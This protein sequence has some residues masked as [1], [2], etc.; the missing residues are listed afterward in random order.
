[1]ITAELLKRIPLFAG[2]PD[3]ERASLAARAAD[4]R[5]NA[6]EWL[7]LEGQT[8]SFFALLEGRLSVEKNIAGRDQQLT[9]FEP[10]DYFGEVPLLLASPAVA[11]VRAIE[12]SRVAR[13]DPLDFH[14]LISHCR[15]LNGEIM[16]TMAKRVSSLQQI[17]VDTPMTAATLIGRQ[18][19]V[20]CL[21]LREFL[22]RNR[23]TFAWRDLD[24]PDGIERLVCDEILASS[25]D[26]TTA[27][28]GVK[29]PLVILNDGRRLQ[30]PKPRELADALGL[31]TAPLHNEYDVV[32]V[33][34]G[35]AGLAAAVY[36]A[37]EGLRTLL[38]E[39]TACGGQAGTS[40]RIENYLG[41]PGGLSGDD[42]SGKARQQAL[43]FNAELL[44]ARSV[45][46]IDPGDATSPDDAEH[47]VVLDDDTRLTTKAV[48]LA[49]G[50]QWRRLDTPGINRLTGHGVYYGAAG[51][52]AFA[53]RG[54]RV[55]LIGGGNSAGQAAMRL[56]DYAELVTML[57]RGPSLAASMS[58]YLINQL[59][60]KA[61]V[62]I[63]TH[64]EVLAAEGSSRLEALQIATGSSRRRER[65]ESD[66]LFVF[67]GAHA[68]TAWLPLNLIRDQ[69][70]Y[71]CTGRDV[72]DLLEEREAGTWPLE[73]DPYLLETSVPGIF[74]AG[75][76]RHGSIKRVASSVGEGSMAIAFVHQ[77]LAETREAIFADRA[78]G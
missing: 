31:Q 45:V 3:D 10:G 62:T 5:L 55:H 35:P 30:A 66:A 77:Y 42:L 64:A 68:E 2:I 57:V 51:T 6:D 69:W 32:I 24:D 17:V 59:A 34:G 71:V 58:Q 53:V 18:S 4:V 76:V 70:G 49:N 50:V 33:G 47:T 21:D 75:D 54:C 16:K 46:A 1:M 8:P 12:A 56:S 36:G 52:E 74:S 19:D 40:S 44:V 15:V 11:S 27:F 41:F 13:L 20:A 25:D 61:N 37:S 39:R 23:V 7:I 26:A 29:L 73:R 67:I 48:I 60:T 78:A 22:A 38:V 65:R 9:V 14:D 43:K 28:A 63:E 72:M